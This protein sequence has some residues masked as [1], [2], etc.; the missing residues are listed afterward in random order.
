MGLHSFEWVSSN[1]P[2]NRFTIML[3]NPGYIL[4]DELDLYDQILNLSSPWSV[5]QVI[6]NKD[7]QRVDVSVFCDTDTLLNCPKCHQIS[8]RYD[9]RKRTWRHLDTCQYPTWIHAGIPR[10][11]CSQHGVIQIDVPWAEQ[12]S[13][14]TAMFECQVIGWLKESSISAVSRRLHISWNAVDGIMRRAVKR[15]LSRRKSCDLKNLAVDEVSSKK[16]RKYVT[17]ISNGR[18]EVIEVTDDRKAESLSSYYKHCTKSQ[19]EQIETISMDMSPAYLSATKQYIDDWESK[20]CFDRFHVMQ[21]LNK[22]VNAVRKTELAIVP[23]DFRAPLHRSRFTWLR[24]RQTLEKHHQ[25]QIKELSSVAVKTARA[26]SIRQYAAT[27][28]DYTSRGW[29]KKAWMKWYGWAIRSR[30]QPIKTQAISIKKNLWGIINAIVHNKNNA[31]AEGINSQIKV[32]KVKARGFR[33]KERFK[34]S[35][36]FHFGGLD[37]YPEFAPT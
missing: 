35:V 22:A 33:N 32:L 9:L 29:A 4:M 28:W 17:I 7:A 12:A 19:L 14:F 27:I 37:L 15:G 26:W 30:L 36:L 16:G 25:Q 21:D 3:F 34:S 24:S 18:G 20:I 6:L 2:H 10:V 5:E 1:S 23:Q 13:R 11:E 31:G 8:S